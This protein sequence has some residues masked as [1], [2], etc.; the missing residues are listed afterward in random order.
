M[1]TSKIRLAGTGEKTQ[2]LVHDFNDNTIRFVLYYTG[3]V[4][5]DILCAA[6]KAVVESVDVLHASFFTDKIGAFWSVNKEYEESSFFRMIE[7]QG[8]PKVTAHSLALLPIEPESKTQLRCYLVQSETAS[9]IALSISHLCVDGSDGKYLL[10]KLVEAYNRIFKT[11]S[12][13]GLEV[14]NGSRAAQKAYEG[15]RSKEYLSLMKN[16]IS[17]I[18]STFPYPTEGAGSVRMVKVD[19]PAD[20]MTVARQKAK[21]QEATANDLLLAACYHAYASMEEVD[22]KTPMSIMSMMD[23]RRHCKDGESEG[24]CNMSGSL[25][26]VL[27]SGVQENFSAT[28]VQIAQQTRAAKEDHLAGLEGMPLLH[29]V[30]RIFPMGALLMVAGKV[31]GSMSIGLTNLGNLS[32]EAL[33]LGDLVPVGG[34]FGGPLKKKP[35]MQVSVISFD[36]TCV[37]SVVGKYTQE[38]ADSLQEMLERMAEEIGKYASER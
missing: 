25:Q 18:K 38:D 20:V 7:T 12:T 3:I 32:C 16:P 36:E 34:M 2:Y 1:R 26:T 10:G 14:K 30:T 27:K 13:E 31:Y 29:G 9:A 5:A 4:D 23:L 19:I 28:L 6:T 17:D 22:A 11:G 35:A 8:D 15:I 21:E 24:L 37:L 33:Q